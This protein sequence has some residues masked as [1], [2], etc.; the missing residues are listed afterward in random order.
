MIKHGLHQGKIDMFVALFRVTSVDTLTL[1]RD[2]CSEKA[3][4]E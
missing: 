3:S 2:I 4:N 1:Q